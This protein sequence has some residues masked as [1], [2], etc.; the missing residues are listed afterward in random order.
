LLAIP[1][2]ES[3]QAATVGLG[4]T[5]IALTKPNHGDTAYDALAGL[6]LE[7][8]LNR[9]VSSGVTYS[10]YSV[11][12]DEDYDGPSASGVLDEHVLSIYVSTKFLFAGPTE[13]Y[14]KLGGGSYTI[15][16]GFDSNST[17][18]A[19][20]AIGERLYVV[21]HLSLALEVQYHFVGTVE[22]FPPIDDLLLVL[23]NVEAWTT[24]RP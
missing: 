5:G 1:A 11:E 6:S 10:G 19:Y 13:T 4:I 12:D 17:L 15:E 18:G 20:A 8:L 16:H 23:L 9:R 7:L 14:F 2:V 22:G 24:D 3:T 21:W